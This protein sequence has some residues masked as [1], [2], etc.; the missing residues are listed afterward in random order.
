MHGQ[1]ADHLVPFILV[2]REH[3]HAKEKNVMLEKR[4][5]N[6]NKDF[7]EKMFWRETEEGE[8]LS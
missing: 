6:R 8:F 7:N 4:K 2:I 3:L 1:G 5:E